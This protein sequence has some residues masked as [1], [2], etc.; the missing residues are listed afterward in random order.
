MWHYTGAI[1]SQFFESPMSAQLVR[2]GKLPPL[3]QRVPKPE[4]RMYSVPADE[5]GTY[6]GIG[7]QTMHFVFMGELALSNFGEREADGFTWRPFVGKTWEFGEDGRVLSFTMRDGLKWSDGEDFDME[8][9]EF[10]WTELK[11]APYQGDFPV[12]YRDPVTGNDVKWNK[13]DDLTFT[14]TFDSPV[15]NIM[16]SRMNRGPDCWIG[17]MCWFSPKH[18]LTQFMPEHVGQAK[19]DQMMKE[20]DFAEFNDFW[21]QNTYS[22]FNS[23]S[24]CARAWCLE[25][26]DSSSTGIVKRNHFFWGF[27]PEGNQMP[28]LDGVQQFRQESR[29]V[30]VFRWFSGEHDIPATAAGALTE[31]PLYVQN[32]EAGDYSVYHWPSFGGNDLGWAFNG[33]W[34]EDPYLGQILR[35]QDFRIAMSYALDRPE[36][37]DAL[38]LSLGSIQNFVPRPDN[39]YYP[40]D[41]IRDLHL[42]RDVAKANQLLDSIGLNQRDDEGYRLR[43]DGDRFSLEMNNT[44]PHSIKAAEL[45]GQQL[46]DVGIEFTVNNSRPGIRQNDDYTSFS[47]SAYQYNPWMLDNT[48]L[49]PLGTIFYGGVLIGIW[50]ESKGREGMAPGPDPNFLPL[51]PPENF[52]ADP[53]GNIKKLADLWFGGRQHPQFSP[54]RSEAGKEIYRINAEEKYISGTVAFTGIARGVA[55]KRN[56]MRN[57]PKTH[58]RDHFGFMSWNYAFEDGQDNLN[59]PGNRSKKYRS[60]SFFDPDFFFNDEK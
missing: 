59:N 45:I 4:D 22:F 19:I 33:T 55:V 10:A 38:F 57:V 46:Q 26:Y 28:Y 34:N 31:V 17:G 21:N 23:D 7:R 50:H 6:G 36:I 5:I 42:A 52:A 9:V 35:T 25:V 14:L 16:E 27:D 29:D 2:E 60:V 32:M 15:Y 40:G 11:Q 56:N 18:F 39:P 20:Q 41:D 13:I 53:S 24:P 44:N 37:N 51:A 8:D 58:I 54:G 43:P 1:P 12:R 3:D 30:A 47:G 49:A 48:H